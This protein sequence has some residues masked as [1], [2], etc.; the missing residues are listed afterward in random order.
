VSLIDSLKKCPALH[1]NRIWL[2]DASP[3]ILHRRDRKQER[4]VVMTNTKVRMRRL[5]L[6][7]TSNESQLVVGVGGQRPTFIHGM[8]P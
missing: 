1:N 5:A 4:R 3:S 7:Q 8:T 6:P 2:G